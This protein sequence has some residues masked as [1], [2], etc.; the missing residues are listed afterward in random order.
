[1]DSGGR[2]NGTRR[3][4]RDEDGGGDEEDNDG[5]RPIEV[6]DCWV[7]F[8]YYGGTK[9]DKRGDDGDEEPRHDEE[10]DIG[11]GGQGGR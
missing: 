2:G 7:G 3:T 10:V 11:F 1:M 5:S 4:G 8:G 9:V 6:D